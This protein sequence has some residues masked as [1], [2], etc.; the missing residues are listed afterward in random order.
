MVGN[1]SGKADFNHRELTGAYASASPSGES[2]R[3]NSFANGVAYTDGADVLLTYLDN[4]LKNPE[5]AHIDVDALPA[6][7]RPLASKIVALGSFVRDVQ[8]MTHDLAQGKLGGDPRETRLDHDNPLVSSLDD[9]RANLTNALTMV[10]TFASGADAPT[11]A[12]EQ[13]ADASEFSE[14]L[15]E[16]ATDMNDQRRQLE[17]D[18]FTDALTGVGNKAAYNRFLQLLWESGESFVVAF[19]DI[20]NLK[21]C[22]DHFGHAEGDGYLCRVSEYLSLYCEET[23]ELFRLSGDE[24]VVLSAGKDEAKLSLRLE[25]CRSQLLAATQVEGSRMPYSFSFGVSRVEPSAGESMQQATVDADRK[26]YG[27]KVGNKPKIDGFDN[28]TTR[29]SPIGISLNKRVFDALSMSLDGRYLVVHNLDAKVACWSPSASRDIGLPRE[30]AGDPVPLWLA[31]VHPDDREMMT[32]T[33]RRIGD[34]TLHSMNLQYRALN[35]EGSYVLCE[36]RGYRLDAIGGEPSLYVGYVVN[37]GLTDGVDSETGLGNYQAL[38]NAI[39]EYRNSGHPVGFVMVNV[40]GLADINRGFGYGAGNQVISEVV[41]RIRSVAS[42]LS[43]LYRAQGTQF[44]LMRG[45]VSL[46]DTYHIKELLVDCLSEPYEVEGRD[47]Q[48]IVSVSSAHYTRIDEQPTAILDMLERRGKLSLLQVRTAGSSDDK[49]ESEQSAGL[50]AVTGLPYGGGF[51]RM[52]NAFRKAHTGEDLSLI[53]VDL[54]NFRTF[55]EWYGRKHGDELLADVGRAMASFVDEGR[56]VA[57]YWGRDDF[58]MVGP[59]GRDFAHEVFDRVQEAIARHDDAVGFQPAVGLYHLSGDDGGA[60]DMERFSKARFACNEAKRSGDYRIKL[61]SS[62]DYHLAERK[63]ELV[64]DFGKALVDGE[65]TFHVQPQCDMATEKVVGA[66]ALARWRRADGTNVSPAVFVPA[67]EDE[68]LVPELDKFI[69]L[70]VFTWL[71]DRLAR[72]LR[73]VP[74]S[75]NV[76]RVDVASF[77]VVA[78][79]VR[80]MKTFEVPPRLVSIEVTE[81]SYVKDADLIGR[82]VAALRRIGFRVYMD[83]FGSGLSSLS[84]LQN[85]EMD[86]IKLDGRFLPK[87]EEDNGRGI[88]IIKSVINMDRS[89]SLP[90]IVEGVET[91]GQVAMLREMGARYAQGFYFYRPMPVSDFDELLDG[92]PDVVD[93]GR[94]VTREVGAGGEGLAGDD[95]AA[96]SAGFD[97]S[98][99]VPQA[100]RFPELD[101]LEEGPEQVAQQAVHQAAG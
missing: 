88:G 67:L 8:G 45:D 92:N 100:L 75:I 73:C 95:E 15:N 52:A 7:Q 66:E 5:S 27:Y 58:G 19:I 32:E 40:D 89:L 51:L 39:G 65:I 26:M 2:A 98:Q 34:G 17:R 71:G 43:Y 72:G 53:K 48:P 101:K 68:G 99:S 93:E 50:D 54:G 30:Y 96:G 1:D 55:N 57:G 91:A 29:L 90:I 14:A 46:E 3:D 86:V 36:S 56:G 41:G 64:D 44:V 79:L 37:R 97:G 78:Y 23:D 21:Y 81:T 9:I 18:A 94:A 60:I 85:I 13:G 4:V 10:E 33:F 76:S 82:L 59:A 49:G 12:V 63:R 74:V 20:D 61:F 83:D 22:N 35:T 70:K 25:T 16:A 24:F 31:T 28:G 6:K 80:L 62:M 11:C 69:W 47:V 42:N 77:D 38:T 84:T 87:D